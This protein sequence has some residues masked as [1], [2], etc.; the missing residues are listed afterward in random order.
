MTITELSWMLACS[1]TGSS[2]R[3]NLQTNQVSVAESGLNNF[4][5]PTQMTEYISMVTRLDGCALASGS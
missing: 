2:N 4:M 1:G 3:T 5:I